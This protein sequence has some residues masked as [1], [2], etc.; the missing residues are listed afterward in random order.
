MRVPFYPPG[1]LSRLASSRVH[2]IYP[3]G[4]GP[5]RRLGRDRAG[6]VPIARG[7]FTRGDVP[8][9]MEIALVGA[10][11]GFRSA[12]NHSPKVMVFVLPQTISRRSWFSFCLK[13]FPGGHGFRSASNHFLEVM[14]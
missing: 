4:R 14:N 8:C 13:P 7:R 9:P 6:E 12:S 2:G 1:G 3:D 5:L 11:H 10:S